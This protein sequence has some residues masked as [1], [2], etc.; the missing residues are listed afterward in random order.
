TQSVTSLPLYNVMLS[1][2]FM[3]AICCSSSFHSYIFF[4]DVINSSISDVSTLL[5]PNSSI[6][7]FIL[8]FF[9]F[10]LFI[11]SFNISLCIL[12]FANKL[13]MLD[14]FLLILVISLLSVSILTRS[15]LLSVLFTSDNLSF[16]ICLITLSSNCSFRSNFLSQLSFVIICF[17]LPRF[18]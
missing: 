10:I 3:I 2:S 16:L 9:L 1:I 11:L 17:G 14:I 15:S 8:S 5:F 18:V 12:P 6:L 4:N 7:T 13:T